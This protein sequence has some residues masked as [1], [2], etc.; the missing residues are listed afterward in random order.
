M[1]ALGAARFPPC[2][3]RDRFRS[4]ALPG[5]HRGPARSPAQVCVGPYVIMLPRT[6]TEAGEAWR[7][8]PRPSLRGTRAHL[9]PWARHGNK[10]GVWKATAA[11]RVPQGARLRGDTS[12][13][14][15]AG[16][17]PG[18]LGQDPHSARKSPR[19][20]PVSKDRQAPRASQ[21]WHSGRSRVPVTAKL[22]GDLNKDKGPDGWPPTTQHPP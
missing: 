3:S 16:H 15:S 19:Q 20:P 10:A 21:G 12:R 4:A 7:R 17:L 6:L 2:W 11:P 18:A 8:G 5:G 1:T 14:A 13:P 9:R 22:A